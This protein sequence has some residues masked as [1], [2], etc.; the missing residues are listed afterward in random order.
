MAKKITVIQPEND[1]IPTEVLATN[2]RAISAGI[3]KLRNGRLKD[4]TLYLLIQQ[5]CT[6]P[7][8]SLAAIKEIIEVMDDLENIYLKKEIKNA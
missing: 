2:I 7:R 1:P 4:T 8:P 3:K 6:H 5:A